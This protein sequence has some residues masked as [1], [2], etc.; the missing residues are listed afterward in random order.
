MTMTALMVKPAVVRC[1]KMARIASVSPVRREAIVNFQNIVVEGLVEVD[2]A[3]VISVCPIQSVQLTQNVVIINVY[4][5][6]NVSDAP[7]N[8]SRVVLSMNHAVIICVFTG[9]IVVVKA[10]LRTM[11]A[12]VVKR[13]V[14]RCVKKARIA[15]VSPVLKKAIVNF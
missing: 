9:K 11:T 12:L 6:T 14:V 8:C 2:I 4:K 3:S 13:V 15:S 7:A 1:V 10:V 5:A